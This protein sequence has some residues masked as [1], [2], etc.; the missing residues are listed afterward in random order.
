MS[1]AEQGQQG[2][3]ARAAQADDDLCRRDF[4]S[5]RVNLP[6]RRKDHQEIFPCRDSIAIIL[7]N[8]REGEY[9]IFVA[10]VRGKIGGTYQ[11]D[12]RLTQS[13]LGD[14]RQGDLL[15]LRILLDGR[16]NLPGVNRL[17]YAG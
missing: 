8:A 12:D 13:L 2:T 11:V 5:L 3:T 7:L 15:I 1:L 9:A 16:R 4:T 17:K 14:L 10:G 6:C